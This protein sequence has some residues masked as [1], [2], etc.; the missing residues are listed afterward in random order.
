MFMLILVMHLF[1][2]PVLYIQVFHTAVSHTGTQLNWI[3][4]RNIF[5]MF[6]QNWYLFL[7]AFSKRDHLKFNYVGGIVLPKFIPCRSVYKTCAKRM[8]GSSPTYIYSPYGGRLTKNIMAW[9]PNGECFSLWK[10]SICGGKRE[11]KIRC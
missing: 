1:G 4:L 10:A 9:W 7:P 2:C 5:S 11:T 3:H 8:S 6:W